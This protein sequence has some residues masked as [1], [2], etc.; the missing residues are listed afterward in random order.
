MSNDERRQFYRA[1]RHAMVEYKQVDKSMIGQ[2][3][4]TSVFTQQGDFDLLSEFHRLD[5]ECAQ[6][7]RSLNKVD[8]NLFDYLELTQRKVNQLSQIVMAHLPGL[9]DLPSQSISLSENGIGF[10]SDRFF[11]LDSILALR[12]VFLPHY[13]SV[14]TFAKVVR[15]EASTAKIPSANPQT[16]KRD[17]YHIAVEFLPL[18]EPSRRVIAQQVL[19]A[20]REAKLKE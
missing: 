15:C 6:V 20:Q 3:P 9:T 5:Q 16:S 1:H 14:I 18:A 19:R 17:I 12:I 7:V 10:C 2:S 8:K 11:Y 4:A 13:Q